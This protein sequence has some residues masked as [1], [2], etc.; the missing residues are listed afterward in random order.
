M[1]DWANSAIVA[2]AV[3]ALVTL[4]ITL[5]QMRQGRDSQRVQNQQDISAKYDKM[6]DYRLQHPE[7][8]S[9]AQRWTPDCFAAIYNQQTEADRAWAYYYGYIELCITY[10]NAV[11]HGVARGLLDQD[12][13][14]FEHEPLIRLL[15][16]EH[17]PILHEIARPGG[18]VTRYLVDHIEA[19]RRRPEG[20]DWEAEHRAFMAV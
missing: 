12:V 20:W 2:A 17:Y 15:L 19:L 18:Y 6:V 10:C 14:E 11:L 8:L 4:V 16:V 9:L 3:S 7:V 5:L 1:S 13:Y